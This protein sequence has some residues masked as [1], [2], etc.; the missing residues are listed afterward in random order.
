MFK[1]LVYRLLISLYNFFVRLHFANR[2]RR[3][4]LFIKEIQ[5]LQKLG[6]L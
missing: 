3:K 2:E 6:K 5:E 1:N 4:R